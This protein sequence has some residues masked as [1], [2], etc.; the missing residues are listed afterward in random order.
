MIIKIG[1]NT[2]ESN[3][4]E[5]VDSIDHFAWQEFIYFTENLYKTETDEFIL[6]TKFQLN[7]EWHKDELK[8][9]ILTD[10]DLLPKTEYR[11]VSGEEADAWLDGAVW[12]V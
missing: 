1:E 10:N 5:M 12:E 2:F 8:N 3:N 11:L 9:G 7:P 4:W 6:E